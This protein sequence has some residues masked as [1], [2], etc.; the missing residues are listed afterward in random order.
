M[1]K[2]TLL[3][4]SQLIIKTFVKAYYELKHEFWESPVWMRMSEEGRGE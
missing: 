3:M 4:F 2:Q 1:L